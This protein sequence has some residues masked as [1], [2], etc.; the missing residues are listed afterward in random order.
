PVSGD[1]DGDGAS[2][3]AVYGNGLW[4]IRT[5]DGAILQWGVPWG[6]PGFQ[7]AATLRSGEAPSLRSTSGR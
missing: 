3:L 7:A 6:G 5:V 4:Y 1:F 2:D